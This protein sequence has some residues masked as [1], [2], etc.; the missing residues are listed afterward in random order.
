M[1]VVPWKAALLSDL[2]YA[3]PVLYEFN[4]FR[5]LVLLVIGDKDTIAFGKNIAAS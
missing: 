5:M 3:Q 1:R 2:I 4:D